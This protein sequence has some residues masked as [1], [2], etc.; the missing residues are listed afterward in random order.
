MLRL[1]NNVKIR[2]KIV[3]AF[4][5]LLCATSGLAPAEAKEA[6][7]K[8]IEN[9]RAVVAKS[10]AEYAPLVASPEERRLADELTR[11]WAAYSDQSKAFLALS[12]AHEN[13]KATGQY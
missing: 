13:E 1:V 9:E 8:E 10:F 6:E 7:N 12:L 2:A 4:V 3:G 11:M 5:L